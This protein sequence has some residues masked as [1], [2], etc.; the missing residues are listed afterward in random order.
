MPLFFGP[1][2][3]GLGAAH[4]LGIEAP[5]SSAARI[6]QAPAP[7]AAA[8][9]AIRRDRS[10][11]V[12]SRCTSDDQQDDQGA[13]DAEAGKARRTGPA[14]RGRCGGRGGEPGHRTRTRLSGWLRTRA[15]P[16]AIAR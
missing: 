13:V 1:S 3:P 6:G 12:N 9:I 5:E 10:R 7:T 14:G 2:G 16:L 8:S 11:L 15:F 4:Y